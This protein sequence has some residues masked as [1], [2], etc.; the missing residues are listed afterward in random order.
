MGSDTFGLIFALVFPLI[1]LLIMVYVG[2]SL[3]RIGAS[4][5][6]S[7]IILVPFLFYMHEVYGH[8]IDALHVL[9]AYLLLV[10]LVTYLMRF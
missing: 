2:V 7:A 1:I 3:E 10:P 4:C 8:Q 9:V 5:L 6:A